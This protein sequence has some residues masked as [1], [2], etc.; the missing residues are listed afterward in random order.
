VKRQLLRNDPGCEAWWWV[1]E[2]TGREWTPVNSVGKT[3]S[4]REKT[5]ISFIRRWLRYLQAMG[6]VDLGRYGKWSYW[7]WSDCSPFAGR[8]RE[9]PDKG[10]VK[11]DFEVLIPFTYPMA[12]RWRLAQF[13][14]Y[15]GGD[16]MLTYLLTMDSV[17]RGRAQGMSTG[18]ILSVL[19][20]IS[21][22][23][24]PENVRI[25]VGQWAEQTGRIAFSTCVLLECQDEL[26][27]DELAQHPDIGPRLQKRVGPAAFRVAE[28]DVAHLQELL[29]EQGYSFLPGLAEEVERMWWRLP[30]PSSPRSLDGR[31]ADSANRE[32]GQLVDAYP[33]IH[34][35]M[36][37]IQHLPRMWTSG[38][39]S[40][41]HST[42]LDMVRKAAEWDLEMMASR[43]GDHPVRF[44]P[45]QVDNIG[46]C[47]LIRVQNG[48]GEEDHWKLEDISHAQILVPEELR[49]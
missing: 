44:F 37:E 3:M 16:R 5:D 10:F 42:I 2:E 11:P 46:G 29:D 9:N 31:F 35:A 48:R 21:V 41:H 6:W 7:R 14:D 27:A 39:R 38:L 47:W 8:V 43:E 30:P 18:E 40:Y 19:E 45:Q 49:R 26:L 36:P 25:G 28:G 1:L 15:L 34:E 20:R 33:E 4:G 12:D 13:A 23:P 17:R 32:A 24:L 22:S